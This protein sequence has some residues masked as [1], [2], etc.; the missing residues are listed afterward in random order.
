MNHTYKVK[1][2]T[3]PKIE[4]GSIGLTATIAP[5]GN[6]RLITSPAKFP[7]MRDLRKACE[8]AN[9]PA[10]LYGM[11]APNIVYELTR[12]QLLVLGLSPQ[13]QE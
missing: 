1:L 9:I 5:Q 7:T 10:L 13:E 8:R 4:S 3:S 12:E 11:P 6:S 2:L